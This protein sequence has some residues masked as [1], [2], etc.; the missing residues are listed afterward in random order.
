VDLPDPVGHEVSITPFGKDIAFFTSSKFLHSIH[1]ENNSGI[2][3]L[4]STIRIT[5]FSQ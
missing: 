3:L 4:L 5:I 1:R 2:F